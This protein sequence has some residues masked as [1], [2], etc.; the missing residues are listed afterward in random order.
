M[1]ALPAGS[2]VRFRVRDGDGRS[3]SSWSIETARHSGDLY[4]AHREGARWVKT[5]FHESGQW[6][7]AVTAAGQSLHPDAQP[8]LGV[9][10]EHGEIGPGWLHAMRITVDRAELRSEWVE[11]VRDRLVVDIPTDASFD[12]VSVDVLLGATGAATIRIDQAFL[13]GELARGDDG[14]AIV[15]ARPTNIDT[16]VRT[17]LASQIHDATEGLRSYG[18]DGSTASRLVIFG[19]DAEGYLRQVEVALDPE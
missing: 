6:H 16:P 5:S 15:V 13:V 9:I 14:S 11:R 17:S 1:G 2:T 8:Y 4:L 10:T 7:Y 19:G 3:G 18:W 12:A